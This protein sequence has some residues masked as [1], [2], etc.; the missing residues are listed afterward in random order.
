MEKQARLF[1]GLIRGFFLY[2]KRAAQPAKPACPEAAGYDLC[3]LYHAS[4]IYAHKG[5]PFLVL[6]R[7]LTED[8]PSFLYSP[9][10][11]RSA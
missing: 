6:F 3:C 7:A 10:V 8:A 1:F 9:M 2:A 5:K 11:S 4:R